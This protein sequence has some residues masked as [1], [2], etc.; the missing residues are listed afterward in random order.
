[1]RFTEESN[2]TGIKGPIDWLCSDVPME[3]SKLSMKW[4]EE[5]WAKCDDQ[6]YAQGTIING[7]NISHEYENTEDI[8]R[9]PVCEL[10]DREHWIPSY[11]ENDYHA[12]TLGGKEE[13]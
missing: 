8:P 4:E 11:I 1:M 5:I 3:L 2:S 7:W 6:E 10:N 13:N 9:L 12:A